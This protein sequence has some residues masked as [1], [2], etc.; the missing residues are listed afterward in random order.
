MVQEKQPKQKSELQVEVMIATYFI[1]L[2]YPIKIIN[3]EIVNQV[4]KLVEEKAKEK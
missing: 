3:D 4:V 1:C 2:V